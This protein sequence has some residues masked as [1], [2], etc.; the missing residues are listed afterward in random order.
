MR[1]NCCSFS[2]VCNLFAFSHLGCTGACE[3]EVPPLQT[4]MIE[5]LNELFKPQSIQHCT[6]SSPWQSLLSTPR[7]LQ[8]VHGNPHSRATIAVCCAALG[9]LSGSLADW[10][11]FSS[12][13][14]NLK[15]FGLRR[16]KKLKRS[17]TFRTASLR[18][19]TRASL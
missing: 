5:Q 16:R 6:D 15:F 12:S 9:T 17:K 11:N 10:T 3:N 14:Y 7:V 8:K 2:S 19:L 13:N 1:S 4:K 18:T